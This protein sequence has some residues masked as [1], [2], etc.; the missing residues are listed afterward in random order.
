MIGN[1]LMMM[2]D[3]EIRDAAAAD[4]FKKSQSRGSDIDLIDYSIHTFV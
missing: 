4:V 2:T 1:R 3:D